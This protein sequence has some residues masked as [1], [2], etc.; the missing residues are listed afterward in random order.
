MNIC[1]KSDVLLSE[2]SRTKITDS[3]SN[4]YIYLFWTKINDSPWNI[5]I[6][7]FIHSIYIYNGI[8]GFYYIYFNHSMRDFS[9]RSNAIPTYLNC[10]ITDATCSKGLIHIFVFIIVYIFIHIYVDIYI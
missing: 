9:R 6:Y 10:I 8:K 1:N 4:I 3:P 2:A 5:Y 7:L